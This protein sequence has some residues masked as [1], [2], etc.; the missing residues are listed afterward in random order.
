M[1]KGLH[2][3]AERKRGV[4]RFGLYYIS[5]MLYDSSM[6]SYHFETQSRLLYTEWVF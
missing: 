3:A 2:K 1:Y 4:D 5:M 6:L